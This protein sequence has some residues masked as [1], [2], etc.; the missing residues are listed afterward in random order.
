MEKTSPS[1]YKPHNP[2]FHQQ[3]QGSV[4]HQI[5]LWV[6]VAYVDLHMQ[7]GGS[8]FGEIDDVP[9]KFQPKFSQIIL[10][11]ALKLFIV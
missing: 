10:C 7:G 4:P 9:C 3:I 5:P 11:W 8:K 1:S 2:F 6:L